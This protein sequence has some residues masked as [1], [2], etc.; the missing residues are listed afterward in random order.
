MIEQKRKQTEKVLIKEY[1]NALKRIRAELA[2]I[3]GSFP[4]SGAQRVQRVRLNNLMVQIEAELRRLYQANGTYL[5]EQLSNLYK[6][7]YYMT[8]WVIEMELKGVQLAWGLLNP[9]V[10]RTAVLAP[11][12]KLTLNKR[13]QRNRR[14]IIAEIKHQLTQGF[15]LGNSYEEMAQR[16]KKV[17]EQ[18]TRKARLIAR[19]EGHRIANT[20]RMEGAKKADELGIEMM[21]V[22]DAT[23]DLRIRSAH[24]KLDGKKIGVHDQ[25]VSDYG[26]RGSAPG[27]MKVA[28]DDCNCRCSMRLELV[29]FEPTVRRVRGAGVIQYKTYREWIKERGYQ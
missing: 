8:G 29:G 9:E 22:W 18:D 6:D 27:I 5:I 21:K 25:F 3:Y 13:L 1:R 19:T 4:Q 17:L 20:A 14:K 7:A 24:G 12:D 11:I 10:I 28:K 2:Q 16:M 26:G 23:L 15:I